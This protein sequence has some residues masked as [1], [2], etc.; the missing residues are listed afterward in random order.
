MYSI[1]PAIE[2][3]SKKAFHSIFLNV[4]TARIV[5]VHCQIEILD[6]DQ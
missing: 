4:L 1:E 5:C 6:V 3:R 2:F